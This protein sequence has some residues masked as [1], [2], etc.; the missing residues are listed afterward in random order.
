MHSFKNT[1]YMLWTSLLLL[2]FLPSLCV[3]E[4][5]SPL[6]FNPD[7]GS[8]YHMDENCP[9]VSS[10]ALP[11]T[12]ILDADLTAEPYAHLSPCP[13]CVAE[14]ICEG[15]ST[16]VS[17]VKAS[18][19]LYFNPDGGSRYHSDSLCPAVSARYL[20]LTLIPDA[21]LT[22]EPY[23]RLTACPL[24]VRPV[25]L[26]FNPG[27]GSCYHMDANCPSVSSDALPLAL[28]PDADLTAEPYAQLSPCPT[29]V[30]QASAE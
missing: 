19:A 4:S 11:L 6:Y 1:L 9:S 27:G 7:G 20:P 16:A 25:A 10:D 26:Y 13:V 18:D 22:V 21:D 8:C 14:A 12:P 29:C 2:F 3:A 17:A 15:P 24:C 5:A 28:I 23:T 30:T